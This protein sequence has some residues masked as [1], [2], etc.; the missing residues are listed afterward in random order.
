MADPYEAC[1]SIVPDPHQTLEPA[2]GFT[3]YDLRLPIYD[4]KKAEK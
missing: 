2:C 3:I 4:L 1:G